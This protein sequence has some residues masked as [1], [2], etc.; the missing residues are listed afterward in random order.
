M[1]NIV[2]SSGLRIDLKLQIF[3][4]VAD[5]VSYKRSERKTYFKDLIEKVRLPSLS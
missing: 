3:N 2:S 4:F 1:L 5:W